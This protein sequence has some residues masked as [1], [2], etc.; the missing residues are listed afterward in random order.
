MESYDI[1][2]TQTAYVR[3][4]TSNTLPLDIQ[5]HE[6]I[7]TRILLRTT[8]LVGYIEEFSSSRLCLS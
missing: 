8:F 3:I 5:S 6:H 7:Y 4:K 1:N 2:I